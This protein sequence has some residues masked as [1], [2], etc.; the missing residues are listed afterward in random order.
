ML[1]NVRLSGVRFSFGAALIAL[2]AFAAAGPA[3]AAD[4][5]KRFDDWELQCRDRAPEGFPKCIITQ[6]VVA[7]ETKLGLLSAAIYFRPGANTP[8]LGFNLAPQA[9]KEAGMVLQIDTKP[10]LELP[11]QSCNPNICVV[12]AALRDQVLNMLRS[13][14]RGIVGFKIPPDQRIAAQLSLKGFGNA[15]KELE[16]RKGR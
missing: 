11:I 6:N 10:A 9:I 2:A 1:S 7:E 14:T 8:S 15:Y 16:K 5:T 4:E 12:R 3:A 13:G